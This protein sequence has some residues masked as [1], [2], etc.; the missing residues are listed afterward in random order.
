MWLDA[1]SLAFAGAV[2][3]ELLYYSHYLFDPPFVDG[4]LLQKD[5]FLVF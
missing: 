1:A 5:E 4:M 2:Q 3:Q